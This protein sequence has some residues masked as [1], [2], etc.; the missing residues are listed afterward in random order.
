MK[1]RHS[2]NRFAFVGIRAACL[3]GIPV[4]SVLAAETCPTQAPAVDTTY[5]TDGSGKTSNGYGYHLFHDGAGTASLTIYDSGAAFKGQWN[6]AGGFLAEVGLVYNNTKTYD[7][8]G[9]IGADFAFSKTGTVGPYS[10]IGIHGYSGVSNIE[11]YIVEDWL[12]ASPSTSSGTLK[13]TVELDGGT[14]KVYKFDHRGDPTIIELP[15][16][17]QYFSI[18]QTPRQCGHVSVSEHFRKW[19]SLGLAL[20]KLYD[21]RLIVEAGGGSGQVTFTQA[22]VVE[23]HATTAVRPD[24]ADG[25]PAESLRSG[26]ERIELLAL[27]GSVVRTWRR[28]PSD[29]RAVAPAGL[30]RG[31]YVLRSLSDGRRVETRRVWVE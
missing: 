8:Y 15:P 22:S 6:N 26:E 18:R 7:Q 30:P 2:W 27:D 19:D 21:V 28:N 5:S 11:Y 12:G 17:D 3:V 1:R 16:P 10:Y 20:G 23:E 25:V 31:V 24:R 4:A 9:P 13:G 29:S 14:Y